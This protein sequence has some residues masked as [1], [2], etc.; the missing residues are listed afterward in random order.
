MMRV[1]FVVY[2]YIEY[3]MDRIVAWTIFKLNP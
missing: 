3:G 2:K 1:R